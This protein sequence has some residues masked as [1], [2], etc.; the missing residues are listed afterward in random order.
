MTDALIR[1]SPQD[2]MDMANTIVQSGLFP[3]IK[4]K[5]AAAGLMMLCQAEGLHPAT[6][7]SRYHIVQG[8]PSMKAETMLAEFQ[9]RG[10]KVKFHYLT[11]EGCKAEFFSPGIVDSVTIEWDVERATK[12]GLMDKD[13]WKKYARA[14]F[15]SR[16]IS[17]GVKTA[18]PAATNG[19][20]TPDETEDFV[21][22]GPAAALPE[23]DPEPDIMCETVDDGVIVAL[24]VPESVPITK[25]VPL[26]APDIKHAVSQFREA[27]EGTILPYPPLPYMGEKPPWTK[28]GNCRIELWSKTS[29]T[30]NNV[31]QIPYPDGK[32]LKD[33]IKDAYWMKWGKE[34]DGKY[35]Y[36]FCWFRDQMNFEQCGQ[37]ATWILALPDPFN[38]S[39][40]ISQSK[41]A[42]INIW[43]NDTLTYVFPNENENTPEEA[44]LPDCMPQDEGAPF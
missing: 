35:D 11:D 6:A 42:K 4:T 25:P 16:V 12:A 41:N 14:M 34:K 19:V 30:G 28:D 31:W 32:T 2:I 37:C 5:E 18:D 3:S 26:I 33:I 20:H 17:E 15:R 23:P 44:S 22:P 40:S 10:G 7:M 13:V 36:G 38:P 8:R 29:G 43:K 27:V 21:V 1:H 9:R 39:I 24:P